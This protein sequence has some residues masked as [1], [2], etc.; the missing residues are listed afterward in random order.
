MGSFRDSLVTVQLWVFGQLI[1]I[2]TC[3]CSL[4][5]KLCICVQLM[6]HYAAHCEFR[7]QWHK[8]TGFRTDLNLRQ[9]NLPFSSQ[10]FLVIIPIV[11]C[12]V[13]M[14]NWASLFFTLKIFYSNNIKKLRTW[15]YF[16]YTYLKCYLYCYRCINCP[17]CKSESNL[18]IFKLKKTFQVF[19][20][21]GFCF[22]NSN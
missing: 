8:F 2:L 3:T 19:S 15:V 22:H 7:L 17:H 10:V 9:C 5:M 21:A 11:K 12:V 14:V 4:A 20:I 1:L 6:L 13:C 16:L 18:P